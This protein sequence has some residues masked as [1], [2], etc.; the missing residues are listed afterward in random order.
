MP[1]VLA[2]ACALAGATSCRTTHLVFTTYTKVGLDVSTQDGQPT[3]AMLGY[4]RFEGAVIPVDLESS[5]AEGGVPKDA[6]SVFAAISVDN[7]WIQGLKIH[8]VFATGKSA[9]D[10]A[11]NPDR[12]LAVITAKAPETEGE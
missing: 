3:Q 1:R 9:E 7:S 4:K 12:G 2:L 6:K 10:V 5:T 8:Q 11:A